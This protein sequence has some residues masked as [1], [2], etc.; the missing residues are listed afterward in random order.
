[1]QDSVSI[2]TTTD[3]SGIKALKEMSEPEQN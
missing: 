1:L 3:I 2:Q